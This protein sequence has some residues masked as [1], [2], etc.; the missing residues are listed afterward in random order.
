MSLVSHLAVK[1]PEPARRRGRGKSDRRARA[2]QASVR[3][4]EREVW[5]I[6]GRGETLVYR[7][8]IGFADSYGVGIGDSSFLAHAVAP[9]QLDPAPAVHPKQ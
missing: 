6:D 2:C 5:S 9:A 8:G 4:A 7:L 3:D 1:E